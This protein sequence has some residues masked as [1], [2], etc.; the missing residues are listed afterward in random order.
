M[1]FTRF[2]TPR[3]PAVALVDCNN[4][5][6]SCE[7][8]FQPRLEGKP[9][10]VL[11]NNDGCVIA[12]SNEAKALG[13]EMGTPLFKVKGLIQREGARFVSSNYALYGDLSRRVMQTLSQFT[14]ELEV[15]SIDEAFLN[16]TGI[17]ASGRT[18]IERENEELIAYAQSIRA[19]TRKWTGIPVSVG[20]APTKTLAKLANR[21]A[22]KRAGS[23]GCFNLRQRADIDDLLESVDVGDV[24]GI[25]PRYGARLKMEGVYTARQLRDADERWIQKTMK[26]GV[27]GARIVYELRGIPC[28]PMELIPASKQGIAC[29]RSFSYPVETYNDLKESVI[30]YTCRAAE[31][32]RGQGSAAGALTVFVMTN[33]FKSEPQYYNSK[34]VRFRVATASSREMARHA[35]LLL[36]QMYRRGYRYKKSGVIL[37]ELIPR[38]RAQTVFFDEWEAERERDADLM[39]AVDRINAKMGGGTVRLAGAGIHPRW[40][41]KREYKTPS[42]TTDWRELKRVTVW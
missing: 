25:G 1:F 29:A 38:D 16:L 42:Y 39:K 24:W 7:R 22:K 27:V 23:D 2:D 4:F 28:I 18:D 37:S 35:V 21:L 10:V 19:T 14:P 13:I 6:A 41:M 12:R 5:Y 11:S 20:V 8:V 9:V 31:K 32:A 30:A 3:Q 15:Y 26:M 40:A 34:T 36:R 33:P 17:F